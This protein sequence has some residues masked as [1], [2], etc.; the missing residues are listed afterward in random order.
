[1]PA[2]EPR[3][4]ATDRAALGLPSRARPP[5]RTWTSFVVTI[6]QLGPAAEEAAM[7]IAEYLHEEGRKEGCIATL[8][9][10]L[11]LKFQTL[12]ADHEARLHAATPEALDR[13]TQRLLIADSLAAVFED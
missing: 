12:D 3:G 4:N 9:S 7:T 11:V 8:R 6:R 2:A 5:R 1:L 10:L 13:Y